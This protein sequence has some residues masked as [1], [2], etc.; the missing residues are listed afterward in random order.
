MSGEMSSASWAPQSSWNEMPSQSVATQPSSSFM[1]NSWTISRSPRTSA[2]PQAR[3][4]YS[5]S[6]PR[7]NCIRSNGRTPVPQ[8][9]NR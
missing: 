5:C 2:V 3:S 8:S 6:L 4:R 1:K 9:I 7:R